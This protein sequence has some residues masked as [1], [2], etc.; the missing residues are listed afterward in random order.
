[1]ITI[2]P[3]FQKWRGS[4]VKI[5]LGLAYLSLSQSHTI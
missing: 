4:D 5:F 3:S 1:M 2:F